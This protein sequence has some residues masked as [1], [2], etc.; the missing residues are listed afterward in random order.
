[1]TILLVS[2]LIQAHDDNSPRYVVNTLSILHKRNRAV[3]MRG[4]AKYPWRLTGT[5]ECPN[6]LA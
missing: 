3:D 2:S 6:K 5:Q 1:M 4:N